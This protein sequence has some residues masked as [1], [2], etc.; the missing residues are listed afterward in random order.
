MEL[1]ILAVLYVMLHLLD[2]V[3][4]TANGVKVDPSYDPYAWIERERKATQAALC[5]E[6]ARMNAILIAE[7]QRADAEFRAFMDTL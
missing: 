3:I 5:A 4:K 2:D 6:Q 7:K 1:M